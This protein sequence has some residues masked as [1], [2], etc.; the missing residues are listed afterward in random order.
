MITLDIKVDG[1]SLV[2]PDDINYYVDK[3]YLGITSITYGIQSDSITNPTSVTVNFDGEDISDSYTASSGEMIADLTTITLNTVRDHKDNDTNIALE[4]YVQI[5][6]NFADE[7]APFQIHFVKPGINYSK[8][9]RESPLLA[10]NNQTIKFEYEPSA[11]ISP[12][13]FEPVKA[14]ISFDG[15]EITV[16]PSINDDFYFNFK[17]YFK[18]S[19]NSNNFN[20]SH[21]LDVANYLFTD[22]NLFQSVDIEVKL[23]SE[24]GE[25]EYFHGDLLSRILLAGLE[26]IE[27][28]KLGK[29]IK[30]TTYFI[31]YP[32]LKYGLGF[33]LFEGY[34]MDIQSFANTN[35]SDY[36]LEN[37]SNGEE[38]IDLDF[39]AGV[40]RLVLS[41]GENEVFPFKK[42]INSLLV[43]KSGSA[44]MFSFDVNYR[45]ECGVYLKWFHP[46]C[47]WCYFLFQGS[48]D[49]KGSSSKGFIDSNLD[50][51]PDTNQSRFEIGKETESYI[52]LY[53]EGLNQFEVGNVS[54]IIESPKV[55]RWLG[56]KGDKDDLDVWIAESVSSEPILVKATGRNKYSVVVRLVK[57]PS[58]SLSV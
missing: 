43:K 20:E 6:D 58:E 13:L 12:I 55:Y 39:S 23:V 3:Q 10:Y 7:D 5:S 31:L 33:T 16:L 11:E 49:F 28:Y 38:L 18:I 54:T 4:F 17:E 24:T 25:L 8:E 40:N 41:D 21:S 50:D 14:V 47:G 30:N 26:D 29:L 9:L 44:D 37:Q 32:Q 53:A 36:V 35:W 57:N 34:P 27:S 2:S 52:D 45:D 19:A 1:I 51:L 46:H 22:N 56:K 15:K 42:G 48:L